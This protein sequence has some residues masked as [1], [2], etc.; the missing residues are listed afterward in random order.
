MMSADLMIDRTSSTSSMCTGSKICLY[1]STTS[2]AVSTSN[3]PQTQKYCPL[4]S[5]CAA[6]VATSCMSEVLLFVLDVLGKLSL[7]DLR[8]HQIHQREDEHP[9]Q[10]DEVP[11][12]PSNFHIMRIVVFGFQKQ[13]HCRDDQSN[14]QRLDAIMKYIVRRNQ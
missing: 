4:L 7:G 2:T 11:V 8:R 9:H 10:I 12:K 3:A 1:P 14:Q 5:S 6:C 13:N